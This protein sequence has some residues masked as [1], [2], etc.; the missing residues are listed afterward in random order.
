MYKEI[1]RWKDMITMK[2][3]SHGCSV[4]QTVS[5]SIIFLPNTQSFCHS[6]VNQNYLVCT[7]KSKF[8]VPSTHILKCN[9]ILIYKVLSVA[10]FE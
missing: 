8:Q 9:I 6:I 10:G 1:G 4:A 5:Q 7:R 2:L 3:V